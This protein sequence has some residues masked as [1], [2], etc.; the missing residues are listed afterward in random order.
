MKALFTTLIWILA[1]TLGAGLFAVST[2]VQDAND[3][4][5]HLNKDIATA[6]QD[7]AILGAEW[8]YLNNP[9]Y[10]DAMISK[11]HLKSDQQN[12]T[13]AATMQVLPKAP[14]LI[15]PVP[16]PVFAR[17]P[18]AATN[19][20]SNNVTANVTTESVDEVPLILASLTE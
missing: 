20:A 9:A 14:V 11:V 16:K 1:F 12:I 10:L 5:R 6:H 18:V 15:K 7:I 19:I 3:L 2:R 8:H 13:I 17:M 4:Q